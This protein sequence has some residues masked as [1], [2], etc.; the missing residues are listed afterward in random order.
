MLVVRP[1]REGRRVTVAALFSG[2]N[3]SLAAT[4]Y[5][6]EHDLADVALHLD[7]TIS[8]PATG[9]FVRETC[10]REGWP[11]LVERA[12][13]SYRDIVL[14]HGF[15]GPAAHSMMYRRLKERALRQF[16]REFGP[17]VTFVSGVRSDESDRRARTV[18]AATKAGRWTW[19][20]P[21]HDWTSSD[22]M[23]YTDGMAR[24]PVSATMCLS[25]DCLCGCFAR[26]GEREE[27]RLWWPEVDAMLTEL[28]QAALAAGLSAWRWGVRP[29]RVARY[30]QSFDHLGCSCS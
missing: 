29:D 19:L 23:R 4:A 22:V 14:E 28:E 26:R 1:A 25:G 3:D 17:T 21:L 11:L 8:A 12:P 6:F 24:N 7:T 30:Q 2:G 20:S 13:V 16:A 10:E 27:W 15:P 9:E 18:E 5:A